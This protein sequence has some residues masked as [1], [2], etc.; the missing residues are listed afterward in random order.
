MADPLL[1]SPYFLDFILPFVLVFTLIFAIL[2]KTQ[3]L[4]ED[5]KQVN[6]LIGLV[7]GLMLIAFPYPR[8]LVVLLMPFL[9]V[10][11]VMLLVFLLLYG[12]IMGK[13]AGDESFLHQGWKYALGAILFIALVSYFVYIAGYWGYVQDFMFGGG[14]SFFWVNFVLIIVI[15]AAIWA[16]IW[17]EKGGSASLDD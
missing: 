8:G 3:L 5:A 12:F 6:A 14:S 17:G 4:G 1:I 10:S 7:V 13:K 2:Q 9:A 11:A 16:V 15:I